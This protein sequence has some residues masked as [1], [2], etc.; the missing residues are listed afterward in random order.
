MECT[1]PGCWSSLWR[2]WWFLWAPEWEQWNKS[3]NFALFD[4]NQWWTSTRRSRHIQA[5]RPCCRGSEASYHLFYLCA[6]LQ[7][8]SQKRRFTTLY[9]KSRN[10][11]RTTDLL[12]IGRP[13][14]GQKLFGLN[15]C[16]HEGVLDQEDAPRA[17]AWH[18][19]GSKLWDLVS[20]SPHTWRTVASALLRLPVGHQRAEQPAMGSGVDRHQT[21]PVLS[22]PFGGCITTWTLRIYGT[23]TVSFVVDESQTSIYLDATSNQSDGKIGMCAALFIWSMHIWSWCYKA[24]DF[25]VAQ[26]SHLQRSDFHQRTQRKVPTYDKAQTI[27][28]NSARRILFNCPGEDLSR[29]HE[30]GSG[31][32]SFQVFDRTAADK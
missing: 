2:T 7:W 13:L 31:N 17:G 6:L 27:A 19:R 12:Y 14:L 15:R 20:S 23:S 10:C 4:A 3:W 5:V 32:C 18:W 25:A 24:H 28:R 22:W 8:V 16:W 21:H 11:W 26:A 29:G 9:R 1:H 30:S